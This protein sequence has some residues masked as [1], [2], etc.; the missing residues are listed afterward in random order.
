MC[1]D[2]GHPGW[3]A[4]VQ[5]RA[6]QALAHADDLLLDTLESADPTA[7][8]ALVAGVRA[9]CPDAVLYANRGLGLLPGLAPLIGG[10]LIEA[11]STTHTPASTL[12]LPD[13]LAYTSHWLREVRSLGL[14]VLALDYA[15]TP[16]LA[17]LARAR[18]A[19]EKVPTFITNR[20]LNLP[21]GFLAHHPPVTPVPPA[22]R[23]LSGR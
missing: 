2:A 12:H 22:R 14:D 16:E 9:R 13:G 18:A 6:T 3:G 10:V 15:S 7:T 21:G 4:T 1:V 17:A 20:A 5:A 8:L 11:F 19:R 23:L